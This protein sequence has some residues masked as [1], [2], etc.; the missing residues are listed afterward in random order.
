MSKA[1][2]D[3]LGWPLPELLFLE[4]LLLAAVAY[5]GLVCMD[6]WLS[7]AW[8]WTCSAF[9]ENQVSLVLGHKKEFWM[10]MTA[11]QPAGNG[12]KYTWC[13]WFTPSH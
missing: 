7:L 9:R 1:H 10:L 12:G 6:F 3:K 2:F 5:R 13:F 4:L 8:P 11:L